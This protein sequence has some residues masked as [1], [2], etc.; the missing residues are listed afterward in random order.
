MALDF[1]SSPVNG[2]V[3]DRYT[4]NSTYGTWKLTQ[5]AG[6]LIPDIIPLDNLQYQFDG[7]E[8]R[9]YPTNGGDI[10]TITNPFRLLI[11]LNGI[12]QNISYP[13][14]VWGTPFS[15]DGITVDS[16]GY[17]VFSEVPPAGSTFTGRIEVGP[18]TQSTTNIYPFKAMDILL[19]AY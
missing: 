14:I 4:Y 9:Y 8:N 10:Q 7:I 19:G 6:Y 16:D 17:I 2:Q 3:Y 12:I 18:A 11:T 5:T 13:E 15:F 1:P